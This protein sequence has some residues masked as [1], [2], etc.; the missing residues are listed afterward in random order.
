M[1]V[2]VREVLGWERSEIGR[3]Q[4]GFM[5][6]RVHQREPEL[7]RHQT[8]LSSSWISLVGADLGGGGVNKKRG[9][10]KAK[11]RSLNTFSWATVVGPKNN[12]LPFQNYLLQCFQFLVFS[13]ISSIQM[14]PKLPLLV[15]FFFT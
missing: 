9:K 14:N 4:N 11:T 13:K 2:C 10:K 15:F 1:L 5:E 7:R 12:Q 6:G 8:G 3:G